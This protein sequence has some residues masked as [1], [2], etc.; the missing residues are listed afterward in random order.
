MTNTA[1]IAAGRILN[2]SAIGDPDDDLLIEPLAIESTAQLS[3]RYLADPAYRATSVRKPK[4]G[5]IKNPAAPNAMCGECVQIQHETR[6]KFGPR[7]QPRNTRSLPRTL[8]H[9]ATTLKLCARHT[10]SWRAI[11]HKDLA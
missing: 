2:P 9:P 10:E 7:M 3:A 4:W 11:D 6:G 1:A 5:S 8:D